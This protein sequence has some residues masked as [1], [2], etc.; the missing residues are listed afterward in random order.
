MAG[1]EWIFVLNITRLVIKLLNCTTFKFYTNSL[2]LF[3]LVFRVKMEKNH[4]AI[5]W[6]GRFRDMAGENPGMPYNVAFRIVEGEEQEEQGVEEVAKLQ[7]HEKAQEQG[8]DKAEEL[9]GGHAKYHV[10]K[11]VA[12]GD[13]LVRAHKFVLAAASPIFHAM[14]CK[15]DTKVWYYY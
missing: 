1:N 10:E 7:G 13:C 3:F 4:M 9:G 5:D 11:T 12:E 6:N 2:V 14:F 8:V 15:A